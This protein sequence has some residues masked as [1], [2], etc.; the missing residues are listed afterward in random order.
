MTRSLS[1]ITYWE[2]YIHSP[3]PSE[4]KEHTN[5][6]LSR[7]KDVTCT[8]LITE[9]RRVLHLLYF[10]F[11]Q[12]I[13][14]PISHYH[15]PINMQFF[16]LPH[17]FR[18]LAYNAFRYTSSQPFNT[19]SPIPIDRDNLPQQLPVSNLNLDPFHLFTFLSVLLVIRK[20]STCN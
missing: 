14:N 8:H 7:V 15:V 4:S 1:V 11:T 19:I 20:I 10:Q 13:L 9:I 16:P 6:R 17:K 12:K 18:T 2:H 3:L 5:K